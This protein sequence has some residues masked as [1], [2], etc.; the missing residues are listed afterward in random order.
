MLR[1]RFL[2]PFKIEPKLC[3]EISAGWLKSSWMVPAQLK[4]QAIVGSF[5]GVYLPFWTFDARTQAD[6]KAE[7]GHTE[8][9]RYFENGEWKTRTVT[10]WRWES[11]HAEVTID[12]L[13]IRA[14][15]RIGPRLLYQVKDFNLAELAPYEAKYL[16]GLSAKAY[17]I[18][19]EKSWDMARSEMRER[20]RQTCI[21]QASTSQIRNFSMKCDFADEDWR[22]VL[23]PVYLASYQYQDK[24]YQIVVNGQNGQISGQRPADWN[25]IWLV[26][27]LL[28]AP[29][30]IIGLIGLLTIPLAGAGLGIGIFGFVLLVIG[31]LISVVIY[32]K[33]EALD[34]L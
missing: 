20:T 10:K 17:D 13:I 28:L 12:D 21:S 29:G 7:V 6:W 8:T 1:P 5:N 30:L 23:L 18:P 4:K 3:N 24:F 32:Q 26:I 9:Q 2:I 33:A 11:G 15:D 22:Y 31:L 16:A 19:L 27:S 34:D 14:T 25:K